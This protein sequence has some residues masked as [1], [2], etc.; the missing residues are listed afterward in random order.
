[1]CY[2]VLLSL[3]VTD[4]SKPGVHVAYSVN[5]ADEKGN[6]YVRVLNTLNSPAVLT[7][8]ERIGKIDI[9]CFSFEEKE[10]QLNSLD[11]APISK[12]STVKDSVKWSKEHLS[13]IKFG[14]KLTDCQKA[15]LEELINRKSADF[16]L[17]E[18]DIGRTHLIEHS[19]DTGN[20]AP[21]RQRQYRIPQALQGEL[22]AQ[23]T[24]RGLYQSA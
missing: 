2:V 18:N 9:G 3:G 7:A 20:S 15:R 16:Q 8:N 24:A 6:F 22:D 12:T 23:V 4:F 13:K 11:S 14:S 21:I 17:N 1:M 10:L 5:C 19:I